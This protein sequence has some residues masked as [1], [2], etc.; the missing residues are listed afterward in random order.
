MKLRFILL[1]FLH[2]NTTRAI[3]KFP[4][5]IFPVLCSFGEIFGTGSSTSFGGNYSTI[6]YCDL[7]REQSNDDSFMC[8]EILLL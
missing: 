8:L 6:V 2:W 5:Q 4:Y 3:V 7:N 1:N